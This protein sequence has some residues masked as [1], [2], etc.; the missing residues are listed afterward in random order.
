MCLSLKRRRDCFSAT[1]H[2]KSAFAFSMP[3]REILFQSSSD[4]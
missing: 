4:S 2:E 3:F 1:A